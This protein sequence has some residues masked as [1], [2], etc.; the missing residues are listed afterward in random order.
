MFLSEMRKVHSQ[1]FLASPPCYITLPRLEWAWACTWVCIV[2]AGLSA[3]V[4]AIMWD[5]CTTHSGDAQESVVDQNDF[6]CLIFVIVKKQALN[7]SALDLFCTLAYL[8]RHLNIFC[9]FCFLCCYRHLHTHM[10]GLTAKWWVRFRSHNISSNFNC[11]CNTHMKSQNKYF[12]S[13]YANFT[14]KN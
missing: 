5:N 12:S 1:H 6:Q 13:F 10:N 14:N 11:L 8:Q 7:A 4:L 2:W 9:C 3:F